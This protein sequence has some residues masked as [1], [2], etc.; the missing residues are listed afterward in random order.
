MATPLQGLVTVL[1]LGIGIGLTTSVFA[2]GNAF[3]FQT[4]G[5]LE[6]TE[7]LVALYTSD[8]GGDLYQPTSYPDYR[9][10]VAEARGFTGLAALRPGVARWTDG[11]RG[12]R[13]IVEIVTGNYFD[14]LGVGLPLGRAFLPEETLLGRAEQ[15]VVLSHH[16]WR[17]RL[18]ADAGVLG[19]T[20]RLNGRDF[21]VIGVAPEGLIGRFLRLNVDA[22]VPVGLAGGFYHSTPQELEDRRDR[23]YMV[24]GRLAPGVS[25][26][27]AQA[28]VA[29]VAD[30]LRAEHVDAWDGDRRE[31]RVF[32]LLPEEES[33]IPPS[34]RAALQGLFG[35]LL[36]GGVG[37]LLIACTNVAGLFLARAA[38]RSREVAVR[39]SL[40]ASRG[41]IV[42]LLLVEASLVALAGGGLGMWLASRSAGFLGS[43]PFPLDVP[44]SF[45]VGVDG[46]VLL[47]ALGV[48]VLACLTF[49]LVPA[50]QATRPDLVRSLR[51]QGGWGRQGRMSL[52]G[53][54]V[55][56]QVA[57]SVTLLVGAGLSLRTA[58]TV[59][60]FP[61]VLDSSDIAL[62]SHTVRDTDLSPAEI[63]QRV[64]ELADR[65][66]A[67]PGVAAVSVASVPE[68]SLWVGGAR[69]KVEVEGHSAAPDENMVMAY[70]AVTP[71]YFEMVGLRPIR[72]R[73]IGAGDGAGSPPVALVNE[74]FASHYWPTGSALGGRFTILERRTFD[75]PY[76]SEPTTFEVVG[77][78]PD[79]RVTPDQEP[80]PFFWTS[81]LQDVTPLAVIHAQARFDAADVVPV[82]RREVVA[83]DDDL[84][85]VPPQTYEDLLAFMLLPVRLASRAFAYAGLFA[86]LLAV[87][88]IYGIV[89][90][91]VSQRSREMAIRQAIGAAKGHVFRTVLVDGMRLTALGLALGLAIALG[92]AH[93]ARGTLMG[94][95]PVDPAA[96]LGGAGVL[97]AAAFLATWVPARRVT[98]SDPMGVLREE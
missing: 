70:N 30:R 25:L 62:V 67:D 2:V 95:S 97:L 11:D 80:E 29:V 15:V 27:Q 32:T 19:T 1:S 83:N 7:D 85:L 91:A 10:V 87:M 71:G 31:G 66:A 53:T 12:E 96:V 16:F 74:T 22:W 46:R 86:L 38:R 81:Y 63:R 39:L 93:L 6:D 50:L 72:G 34:G 94:V 48:S 78:L 18:G 4:S 17:D 9:D 58:S 77:V 73:S 14:V 65:V 61:R 47:F 90:F 40:G 89:S 76:P 51:E 5:G 43:I 57:A 54:L 56:L 92:G 33:R 23:D 8:E 44:L 21:T 84:Q 41:R 24:Y 26:A 35:F 28:Q 49:G 55:V 68:L 37:V 45:A 59:G 13:V 98:R 60:R 82:L 20:V 42:R 75:T 69:G 88:G 3:L 36:A 79:V 52:R 64:L